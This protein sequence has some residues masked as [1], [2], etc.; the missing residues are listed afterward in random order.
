M[1]SVDSAQGSTPLIIP[2]RGELWNNFSTRVKKKKLIKTI[3]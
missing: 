2:I 3:K 1:N